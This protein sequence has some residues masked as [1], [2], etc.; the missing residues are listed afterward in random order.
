MA[1]QQPSKTAEITR[2]RGETCRLRDSAL[3]KDEIISVS[4]QPIGDLRG[5]VLL[6][7]HE[8]EPVSAVAGDH[9]KRRDLSL[10]IDICVYLMREDRWL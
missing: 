6:L 4:K 8:R 1:R 2:L 9:G 3:P 5:P 7:T 10:C